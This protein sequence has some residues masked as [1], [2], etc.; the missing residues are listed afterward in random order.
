MFSTSSR[1]FLFPHLHNFLA[2]MILTAVTAEDRAHAFRPRSSTLTFGL[3]LYA[4][5][6]SRR[7]YSRGASYAHQP[8]S[9]E[10]T[11]RPRAPFA[12]EAQLGCFWP[13]NF[14]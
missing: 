12:V 14:E 2:Y 5:L 10:M 11:R 7:S 9:D 3:P 4:Q 6:W 1:A 13:R 8:R